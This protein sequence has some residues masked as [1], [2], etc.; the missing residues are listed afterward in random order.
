MN[1][2]MSKMGKDLNIKKQQHLDIQRRVVAHKTAESWD[3]IPHVSIQYEPDITEFYQTFKDV[4]ERY[5]EEYPNSPKI[6]L[7]TVLLKAIAQ[8]LKNAPELN[9]LFSYSKKSKTG[10]IKQ[11]DDVNISIPYVYDG[12]KDITPV[13]P[14]CDKK[15]IV[16]IAQSIKNLGKRVDNTN[17]TQL[18]RDTSKKERLSELRHG[19][20]S[21]IPSLLKGFFGKQKVPRLKGKEKKEYYSIPEEERL[22]PKD[23]LTGSVLVSNIGSIYRE[24]RG[25]IALLE[26]IKPQ[27][28]VIGISSMQDKPMVVKDEEGEK[29]I[30]IRKML[31][32][33]LAFD[34]RPADFAHLVP[35]MK[36]MD[37]VFADPR[38]FFD[39]YLL[40][41]KKKSENQASAKGQEESSLKVS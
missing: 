10:T 20:L 6:S 38:S 5:R 13:I 32:F 29:S 37:K 24:F 31:S 41:E 28:F 40:S 34:H 1:S 27:T 7:N 4:R 22:T 11:V 21:V 18:L 17:I 12:H 15:S 19:K 36:Y 14:K 30:A 16:Q 8:G 39:K 33:C 26:I 2:L 3:N 35:F 25:S 9:A 23:L